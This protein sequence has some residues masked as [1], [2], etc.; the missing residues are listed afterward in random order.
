[1]YH[2]HHDPDVWQDDRDVYL[3]P[4]RFDDDGYPDFGQ[5]LPA[6][7]ALP[8]PRGVPDPARLLLPGDFDAS[9]TVD[10]RDLAAFE[11]L[12]GQTSLPWV[13]ADGDG[14][15][16]VGGGDLLLWQ[17]QFG[18]SAAVSAAGASAAEVPSLTSSATFEAAWA[19]WP[20]AS[21][22]IP[23]DLSGLPVQSRPSRWIPL[24]PR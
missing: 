8:V 6:T 14:D 17:R 24:G 19:D 12:F 23:E 11:P 21:W 16:F 20:A 22:W 4:F 10:A 15:G 3:Q 2:A 18:A 13:S 5:P 9:A 7:E 1:M